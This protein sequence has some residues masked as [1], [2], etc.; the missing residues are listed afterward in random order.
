MA[1]TIGS[2]ATPPVTFNTPMGELTGSQV[3]TAT[4]MPPPL[5]GAAPAAAAPGAAQ[6]LT[7]AAGGGAAAPAGAPQAAAG[8][9]P[10]TGGGDQTQAQLIET[11]KSLVAVLTQ[12]IQALSA[13]AAG[14]GPT[15]PSKGGGP[16]PKGGGDP[17]L[18]PGK[19]AGVDGGGI[20]QQSPIQ[21]PV[22]AGG[23]LGAPGLPPVPGAPP[24]GAQPLPPTIGGGGAA[25]GHAHAH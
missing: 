1:M 6:A 19:V 13:Q 2:G 25:D 3:N 11:L 17:G 10:V 9:A 12:L 14:G 16:D 21:A 18:P 24:T 8:A 7:G 5:P 4:L 23:G 15:D 20:V 22:Q